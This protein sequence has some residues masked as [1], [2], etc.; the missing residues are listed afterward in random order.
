MSAENEKNL[1]MPL[2]SAKISE[3]GTARDDQKRNFLPI[4]L[5]IKKLSRVLQQMVWKTNST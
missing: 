3:E 2:V 1:S 5:E 4:R